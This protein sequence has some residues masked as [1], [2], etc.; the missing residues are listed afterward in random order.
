MCQAPS[1]T[2]VNSR[3]RSRIASE[4]V[5]PPSEQLCIDCNNRS[6]TPCNFL[7]YW[8]RFTA[9]NSRA[10]AQFHFGRD[11]HVPCVVPE[12]NHG[13]RE[14]ILVTERA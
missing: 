11:L 5:L 7:S 14:L 10:R 1:S 8:E 6:R 2:P 13:P 9:I 12:A 3:D 4:V